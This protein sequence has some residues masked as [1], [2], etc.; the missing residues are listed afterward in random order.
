MALMGGKRGFL[1]FQVKK[2]GEKLVLIGKLPKF[3]I[4]KN[5]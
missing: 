1:A 2:H 4:E 3:V 5:N